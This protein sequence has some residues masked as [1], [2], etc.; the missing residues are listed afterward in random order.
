MQHLKVLINYGEEWQKAWDEHVK[1][2]EPISRES[3]YNNLTLWTDK[4]EAGNG[5]EGYVRASVYNADEASPLRT[6]EEQVTNP[7]CNSLM[8]RCQANLNHRQAYYSEP[9]TIPY[10]RREWTDEIDVP[11]GADERHLQDNCIIKERY[12][13]DEEEREEEDEEEGGHKYRYTIQLT[14][15]KMNQFEGADVIEERHVITDVPWVAIE[16]VDKHYTSDVFLKNAF[17]HEMK[18]P[19]EIFPKAWMNLIPKEERKSS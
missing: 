18:L 17:R 12:E 19:D 1:T 3:D 16:F 6:V 7:Y 4:S 15:Q 14:V 8:I 9:L 11:E 2:W 10:F 5:K 13:I